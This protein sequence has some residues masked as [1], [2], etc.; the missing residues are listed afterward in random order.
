[1]IQRIQSLYLLL[2][3]VLSTVCLARPVGHFLTADSEHYATLYNLWLS[4]DRGGHIFSPWALFALL[5]IASALTFIAIFLFKTRALQ[6][7]VTSL[8]MLLLVGY[9]VFFA[10]FAYLYSGDGSFRPTLSAAL[11]VVSLVLDYLAFRAT[12]HD[13]QLIRSLDRLR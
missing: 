13:E 1:M 9:Y 8:C 7:R 10:I 11:P 3:V 12:L 2:S 6:M 5:C 4:L